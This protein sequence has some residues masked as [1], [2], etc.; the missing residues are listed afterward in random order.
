ML[1]GGGQRSSYVANVEGKYEGLRRQ[2]EGILDRLDIEGS[3]NMGETV[4]CA[5]TY[6][7]ELAEWLV[8]VV[9]FV[10]GTWN[11]LGL[12]TTP[13]FHPRSGLWNLP[14]GNDNLWAKGR[15]WIFKANQ[16]RCTLGNH[17]MSGMVRV[18]CAGDHYM[19]TV[20]DKVRETVATGG[21]IKRLL[22]DPEEVCGRWCLPSN[23]GQENSFASTTCQRVSSG[24][25][26]HLPMLK[27][28]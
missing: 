28:Q 9:E 22:L 11:G 12:P 5:D 17:K 4:I 10:Y 6:T 24:H 2:A 26:H 21:L 16:G 1:G 7:P 8:E 3:M 23:Y 19:R 14:D 13:V 20:R 25:G 15:K 27:W 18:L